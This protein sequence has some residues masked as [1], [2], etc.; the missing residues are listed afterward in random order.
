MVL[1]TINWVIGGTDNLNIHLQQQT[2][3]TELRLSE[4]FPTTVVNLFSS[5]TVKQ[6]VL[7]AKWILQFEMRP[8]IEGVAKSFGHGLC[9]CLKFLPVGTAAG[10]QLLFCAV[11]PHSPPLIVVAIEPYRGKVGKILIRSNLLNWK[12]AVI[13]IYRLILC[14][15]MEKLPCCFGLQQKII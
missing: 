15:L 1:K 9:P 12:V 6:G 10:N 5:V 2:A 11:G 13:I 7:N 4:H 8:V 14:V 3:G